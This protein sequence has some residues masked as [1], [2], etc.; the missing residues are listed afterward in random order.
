MD[1]LGKSPVSLL[2]SL[3]RSPLSSGQRAM[4]SVPRV[5][6]TKEVYPLNELDR[7]SPTQTTD[8]LAERK[9]SMAPAKDSNSHVFHRKATCTSPCRTE[10]FV[11]CGSV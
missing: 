6:L 1:P 2:P 10:C 8:L 9:N 7:V 3:H 11:D 4:Q 5:Q